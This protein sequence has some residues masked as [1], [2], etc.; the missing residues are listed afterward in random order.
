[1]HLGGTVAKTH[2]RASAELLFC[3]T[4]CKVYRLEPVSTCLLASV[5]DAR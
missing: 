2:D 5:K 3:L 1:L 4:D